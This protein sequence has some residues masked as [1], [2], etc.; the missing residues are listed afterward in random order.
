MQS[1]R[2]LGHSLGVVAGIAVVRASAQPVAVGETGADGLREYAVR[3][4][5]GE[6]S[7]GEVVELRVAAGIVIG[8]GRQDRRHHA[9]GQIGIVQAHESRHGGVALMIAQ[10]LIDPAHAS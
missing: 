5:S 7:R 1:L 10:A 8:R 3:A 6:E 2:D 9:A 4:V